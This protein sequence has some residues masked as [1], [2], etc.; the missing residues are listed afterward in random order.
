MKMF[1]NFKDAFPSADKQSTITQTTNDRSILRRL[2]AR[3]R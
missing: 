1:A 2:I 3:N